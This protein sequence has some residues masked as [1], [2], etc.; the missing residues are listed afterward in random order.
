MDAAATLDLSDFPG[1]VIATRTIPPREATYAPLPAGLHPG[2]RDAL[3]ARGIER[4]YAHQAEAFEAARAGE[5]IVV[6]TGT[7]SGKS[8]AYLLPVIQASLEEPTARTLLLF[9]TK[10]L[11]QDQL[12]GVTGLVDHLATRTDH[13]AP[14]IVAGVYDGDTPPAE[15]RRTRDRAHLVMTNPDMLHGALLPSHGRQGFAHLFRNVKYVVID[16]LHAYR[17][18]FGAHLANV[19]R[20]LW[21]VCAHH[22]STPQLLCSSATIA[23]AREHAEALCHHPFRLIDRDG[24]PSAGKVV[25]FW[26]PPLGAGD[27]RRPVTAELATLLPH[28]ITARHRTIA[29]CRSR[30]DTEIVLKESR[31]RLRDVAGHDEAYLLAGYRGGYTPEERRAV[32]RSLVDGSLVGVVSTNA[33]ELGIDIGQLQVVVQAGFPGTRASFWQQLGRAGRRGEVAHAVLVLAVS[34]TDHFVAEHPDWLVGQ[35]AEHAVI[36]RDNLAIQLA[37][38][39]AAAAELPLGL[40]D[41]SWFPDLGEIVAVLH[42][43]GEVRDVIGSWHWTGGAF[44]AGEV[45]LRNVHAD[46]F[47]VV[48]RVAETTITEMSRPQVYREAHPR[49]IYLHDGV[50]YQVEALDLVQHVATVV[51]VEQNFYTQP[52]VRSAID[53]LLTQER[54]AVGRT[55]A[56]FGDVRVDDVVVGYKMLEFHN[57][58]NLG[59]EELHE[60]LR[61]QLDT[62]ALWIAVPDDV[63]AVLGREREDALAGMVHAVAACARLRTM[64][65]RSDLSGASFHFTDEE[66]GAAATALVCHDSHPGG[67]GY[68]AKAFEYVDGVLDDA[69]ALVTRC[70]CAR[71]CPACVGSW[72]RDTELVGWAL[73]ALR[74]EPSGRVAVAAARAGAGSAP[75]VAAGPARIPWDEV[76]VR[77]PDIVARLRAARVDGAALL[78]KLP[79]PVRQ[80]ARLV[81]RVDGPGVARWLAA[82]AARRRLWRAIAAQV[83]APPGADLAIEVAPEVRDRSMRTAIRLQRRFD[84]LVAERPRSEVEANQK[85]ASGYLLDG[86]GARPRDP[87]P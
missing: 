42:R 82:D 47:K 35:P 22:G 74:D 24:S 79:P 76:D 66:T 59:Y 15:R 55:R 41:A 2:L 69:I 60:P 48:D 57:H 21:R 81:V 26:Q 34:P 72:A 43:A 65:E 50:Q 8:L 30:K 16:E 49:A 51:E 19:L 12:R 78:E 18:A 7:A 13:A 64:A 84:D 17:G 71:G 33:L 77:W 87:Q 85:L 45:S 11:T 38:V 5:N 61:L 9:P 63:L 53:V 6:T 68:A 25:H 27:V 75:V 46:R 29:F 40:D 36:D 54:R 62:E 23:N 10:A 31:D 56:S 73:R 44:P 67:L 83:D 86:D 20:R 32:E 80:G 28:L 37:H 52:D 58:Q 3:A 39:R 70:A 14:R 4:L 1:R